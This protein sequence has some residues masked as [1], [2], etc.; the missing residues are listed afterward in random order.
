[1]EGSCVPQEEDAEDR[2]YLSV[3]EAGGY[4]LQLADVCLAYI[5]TAKQKLLCQ[6]VMNG[7]PT[8]HPPTSPPPMSASM[9]ELPG[10][11]ETI[12]L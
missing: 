1:M 9:A 2:S 5:A 12:S 7:M 11:G 6:R 4:T 8:A 10:A 3:Q